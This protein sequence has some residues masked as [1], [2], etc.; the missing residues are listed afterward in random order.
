MLGALAFNFFFLPPLYTLTISDP[1]SVV[2]LC[3]LPVVALDRLAT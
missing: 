1:E 3:L 2:A